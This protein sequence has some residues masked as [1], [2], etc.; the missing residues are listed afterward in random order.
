MSLQTR[1]RQIPWIQTRGVV[2]LNTNHSHKRNSSFFIIL[3]P[4]FHHFLLFLPCNLCL[5]SQESYS[6]KAVCSAHY[7][8][9]Y[10]SSARQQ[11]ILPAL[12]QKYSVSSF[13]IYICCYYLELFISLTYTH[14]QKENM[15][16]KRMKEFHSTAVWIGDETWVTFV[17]VSHRDISMSDSPAQLQRVTVRCHRTV[18]HR[19]LGSPVY[20]AKLL[21]F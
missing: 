18:F 16:W 15:G 17:I 19:F 10:R 20:I 4:L 8:H 13:T 6:V 14:T 7:W 21:E 3:P 2:P 5:E 1:Q 12:R 11:W 9:F